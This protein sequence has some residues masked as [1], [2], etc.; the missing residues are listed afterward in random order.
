MFH[1]VETRSFDTS[2]ENVGTFIKKRH[3]HLA[4]APLLEKAAEQ[5]SNRIKECEQL[6]PQDMALAHVDD[7]VGFFRVETEHHAGADLQSPE[8]R[9]AAALGR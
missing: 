6:G 2:Q 7:L 5:R 4:G 3:L 8:G 1:R 9:T